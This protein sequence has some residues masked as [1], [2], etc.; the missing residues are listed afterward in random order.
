MATFQTDCLKCGS[1]LESRLFCFS[2]KTIQPLN[3]KLNYFELLGLSIGFEVDESELEEKYHNLS[4]ELHPDFFG[5]APESEKILS[6]KASS[7]LNTAY[8]TIYNLNSRASYLLKLLSENAKLNERSLP[9]GFL[10]EMFILQ[11]SLDEF[12]E[13]EDKKELLSLKENLIARQKKIELRFISLFRE[14]KKNSNELS[15]LQELQTNLNA[16]RYLLRLLERLN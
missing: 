8:N 5:S 1:S 7:I 15:L 9:E 4:L 2:C 13:S 11:E 16:E 14:L 6:E 10:G 3:S 12:L